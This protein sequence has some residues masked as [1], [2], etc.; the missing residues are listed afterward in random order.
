MSSRAMRTNPGDWPAAGPLRDLLAFL[1]QV[2]EDNGRPGLRDIAKAMSLSSPGR[3]NKILRGQRP[4]SDRAQIMDLTRALGGGVE[5]A[6]RAGLLYKVAQDAARAEKAARPAGTWPLTVPALPATYV[7]RG[8]D[9]RRGSDLLMGGAAVLALVGMGGAGKSTTAAAVAGEV[10]KRGL[11]PDGVRWVRLG[12]ATSAA[13]AQRRLAAALGSTHQF[14]EDVEIGRL[15]LARLLE[16][17]RHLVVLDDAWS[18]D[19]IRAVDALDSGSRLLLTTRDASLARGSHARLVEI[20][21]LPLDVSR[22]L[23]ATWVGLPVDLLPPPADAIC[24]ESGNLALA[25]AMVG[26]RIRAD[27]GGP[28]WAPPWQDALDALR[29]ADP[30]AVAA[31]FADYEHSTLLRAIQVG[32]D[33]LPA[34]ER[35]RYLDLAIFQGQGPI[36]SS[37]AHRLWAGWDLTRRQASDCLRRLADRSLIRRDDEGRF[38][39][40]DLQ[41]DVAG[42]LL[43][44][45][46]GGVAG[47]HAALVS[48][49][50][51]RLGAGSEDRA[52][53]G[54]EHAMGAPP[55]AALTWVEDPE[56]WLS[57]EDGYFLDHLV[58][59]LVGGGDVGAA[60]DLLTD[61]GWL[62]LSVFERQ[63]TE[64]IADY[65][66]VEDPQVR[67]VGQ[68]LQLSLHVLDDDPDQLPGQ[69]LGRLSGEY[70]ARVSRLLAALAG[71]SRGPWLRPLSPSLLTAGGSLRL[72]LVHD[73]VVTGLDLTVD[74]HVVSGTGNGLVYIWDANSGQRQYRLAGHRGAVNRISVVSAGSRVISGSDESIRFW[75][76]YSGRHERRIM[77]RDPHTG[78]L[79]VLAE[80][81]S[82]GGRVVA[83][84]NRSEVQVWSDG[85]SEA[86]TLP[87]PWVDRLAF[88]PDA[89]KLVTSTLHGELT[90]WDLQTS[91]PEFTT[92]GHPSAVTAMTVSLGGRWLF[93]GSSDGSIRRWDLTASGDG[94]EL[95]G[96]EAGVMSLA[97]D[98]AGVRLVSG[99]ASGIART[100]Q[101]EQ[102]S[103]E[104]VLEGHR[105][106]II[107]LALDDA[108]TRLVTASV[109]G[110]ARVWDVPEGR[111]THELAGHSERL[112]AVRI[113]RDGGRAVTASWDRTVRV[114]DLDRVS[115]LERRARH[116]DQVEDAVIAPRG[117]IGLS[118]GREG[119]VNLWDM[120]TGAWR[121]SFRAHHDIVMGLAVSDRRH[122]ALSGSLDGLL[123]V[124][125]LAASAQVRTLQTIPAGVRQEMT[126]L[127]TNA[128]G[129]LAVTGY[130]DGRLEVW[131]LDR[132]SRRHDLGGHRGWISSVAVADTRIISTCWDKTARVWD[133]ENG[134]CLRVLDQHP[135]RVDLSLVVAGPHQR[136]VTACA[137][138]TVFVW[139]DKG[140]LEG[141]I[142]AHGAKV[143]ALAPVGPGVIAS[144]GW[145]NALR[146]WDLAAREALWAVDLPGRSR[147]LAGAGEWVFT[148]TQD[149]L[150]TAWEALTGRVVASWSAPAPLTA[151][152]AQASDGES[153]RL[154]V[155]DV[156]GAVHLLRLEGV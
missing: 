62:E 96:H 120:S 131:D 53:D 73:S 15:H 98:P 111:C 99:D 34:D 80:A 113:S 105:D 95:W 115:A 102:A 117:D 88:T 12:R 100:W 101:V 94:T 91:T 5:E 81:F 43:E 22:A 9:V 18:I 30:S 26:A 119:S 19:Q 86:A 148:G 134:A 143:S 123:V 153:A 38:E 129:N 13:Q 4:A 54:A 154:L 152:A 59:H 20:D 97:V 46:P 35:R 72:T 39:L 90:L 24:V 55:M 10:W 58:R 42:Y 130:L 132:G 69:F 116:Q 122:Q 36:P 67:L 138:G 70:G 135:V 145:D 136:F 150:V 47:A 56:P 127:A 41:S 155:G 21:E 51:E 50:G 44:R 76:I 103:G 146:V 63:L 32:I 109:D 140:D 149:G 45:E 147:V 74:G 23:L 128:D 151:L 48:G 125:D 60:A 28:Q 68:A 133:L 2:R 84:A 31:T 8:A 3:V 82:P 108:G 14:G 114:W 66:L 71:W 33:A 40:H 83:V 52:G 11:V 156:T 78:E 61:P 85:A 87:V 144:A 92:S 64:V 16:G 79:P 77:T 29:D 142:E 137:D 141:R 104:H 1:D 57:V 65:G 112:S 93:T 124:W 27:N 37:V 6:E 17:K 126:A 89:D 107:G 106:S 139:D 7:H 118:A 110:T 121:G 75:N 49:Y 25:V